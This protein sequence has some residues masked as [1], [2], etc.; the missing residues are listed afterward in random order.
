MANLSCS[1]CH[2]WEILSLTSLQAKP[3]PCADHSIRRDQTGCTRSGPST[4][5]SLLWTPNPAIKPHVL[6]SCY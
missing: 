2:Q 6:Q 4:F 3:W 1:M 5:H